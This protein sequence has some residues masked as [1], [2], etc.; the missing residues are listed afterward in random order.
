MWAYA[1]AARVLLSSHGSYEN[2]ERK[3]VRGHGVRHLADGMLL[4]PVRHA[5]GE[6][7]N[8]QRIAPDVDLDTGECR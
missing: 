6:L 2:L 1:G 7:V 5:D 3:G 8:L 4:V